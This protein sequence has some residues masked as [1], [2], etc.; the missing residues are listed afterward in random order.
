M[1]SWRLNSNWFI[2]Q[3][4]LIFKYR[5]KIGFCSSL[6]FS[7]QTSNPISSNV[8]INSLYHQQIIH[9]V[10]L[11]FKQLF[12]YFSKIIVLGFCAYW[13]ASGF[14]CQRFQSSHL[15]IWWSMCPGLSSI[16]LV[17]TAEFLI[18]TR[19]SKSRVNEFVYNRWSYF[20]LLG[21]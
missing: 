7:M 10:Y 9:R 20:S 16:A 18:S 1:Q 21:V 3:A 19:K 5:R 11:T 14:L 6:S 12:T 13:I 8:T 17:C 2:F 4:Y 15:L